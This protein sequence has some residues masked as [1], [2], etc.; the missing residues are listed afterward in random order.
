MTANNGRDK[1]ME[2]KLTF[3]VQLQIK[4]NNLRFEKT[5]GTSI[6]QYLLPS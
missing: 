6:I 5:L 4:K 2:D 3:I 1:T